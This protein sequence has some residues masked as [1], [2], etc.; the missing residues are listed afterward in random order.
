MRRFLYFLSGVGGVNPKMLSDRGLISRFVAGGGQLVEHGATTSVDGPR[1][2][3]V[4]GAADPVRIGCIVAAG[5]RPAAYQPD[6]QRWIPLANGVGFVGLEDVELPPGPADLERAYG[7]AGYAIELGDGEQWRVPLV[8]RWDPQQLAHV[9]ALP[10]SI[11]GDL[12]DGKYKFASKVRPEY[13][14]ID[15][16]ADSFFPAFLSG[17]TISIDQLIHD[18]AEL[19]AVN[20]R[21]GVEEIMLLGLLNEE[22]ALTIMGLSIDTPGIRQCNARLAQQ[23][24][25]A[26]ETS[27]P[28][29]DSPAPAQENIHG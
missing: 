22:T 5:T 28:A 8:K 14:S 27:E 2:A 3:P 4:P 26:R 29:E 25:V 13:M 23:G 7:V 20:Y 24:V 19:L 6:R 16:K 1:L 21:L 12:V 15:Q 9:S 10:S 17:K 18:A 11:A